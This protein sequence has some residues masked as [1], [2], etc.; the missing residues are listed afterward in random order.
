[1]KRA[2]LIVAAVVAQADSVWVR[3]GDVS[4]AERSIRASG[5]ANEI[6]E[7]ERM[8]DTGSD[9]SGHFW[10]HLAAEGCTMAHAI[11]ICPETPPKVRAQMLRLQRKHNG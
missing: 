4:P 1:M 8:M 7:Y 9:G 10:D 3:A 6:H 11:W 5:H 2:I